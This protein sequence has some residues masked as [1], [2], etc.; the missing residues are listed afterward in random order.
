LFEHEGWRGEPGNLFCNFPV[1]HL[2]AIPIRRYSSRRELPGRI[3][4]GS[5]WV[6]FNADQQA[7]F[8]NRRLSCH[9]L[10]RHCAGGNETGDSRL[11]CD[12]SGRQTRRKT[13]G[14]GIIVDAA[15][16]CGSRV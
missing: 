6:S 9:E 3:Q 13:G 12:G 4:F 11:A 10:D 2:E 5:Q 14:G 1:P 8:I 7:S 16:G 15:G